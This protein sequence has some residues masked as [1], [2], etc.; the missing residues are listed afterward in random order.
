MSALEAIKQA[1][2][3]G[4]P[5]HSVVL[6]A[7]ASLAVIIAIAA[8]WTQAELSA[9]VTVASITLVALGSVFSYWRR[10][11]PLPLLK[12]VLAICVV[13]AFYWFFTTISRVATAGDLGSVEGP[14]AVLFTVIQVTHAFDVPSRRDLAFSLAGSATLM[15]VAAAQAIDITFGLYVVAWAVCGLI[16]LLSLWGSMAG[17]AN[18][19][20]RSVALVAV[21]VAVLGLA[22][23]VVL[24]APH[25]NSNLVLPSSLAGDVPISQPAA[26]VGG[27]AKGTQPLK[28]G[29]PSGQTRVG[30]YLGFA[31]PLDTAIRATLG[32]EIVFRVRADRPTFWLAE[33][34]DEWSGTSWSEAPTPK[35]TVAWRQVSSG[36]PFA[37]SAPVG[38]GFAGQPDYQ[39]FYIAQGGPNLVFHAANAS[40]VWFPASKLY[41]GP[42][43]TIRSGTSM[44]P[45]SIY[46]VLSDVDQA[47]P[48]QLAS[49][50]S[51]G[52]SPSERLPAAVMSQ[53]LQLPHP[54]RRAAALAH[55]VTAHATNT[56]AKV[57]ALEN[58]IG[59]HTKYTTDIPPLAP[60]QDTVNEFLFGNRRGYC[61]QI[62]TAL[63]VMLRSLGIPAREATG[64]VP[65]SYDPITD[66]YQEEAKDA[67]AWV[68]VWF[69]GYGWQSF[70]PTAFVPLANPSPGEV[71]GHDALQLLVK[72][73]WIPLAAVLCVLSLLVLAIR[74]VRAAPRTWAA[75]ISRQIERGARKA[76][77]PE[78]PGDTLVDVARRFDAHLGPERTAWTAESLADAAERAAFG[79]IELDR[80]TGRAL[81]QQA[82]RLRR[83]ARRS[84]GRPAPPGPRLQDTSSDRSQREPVG[85]PR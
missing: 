34:F 1:N 52:S 72:I 39:T 3:P 81:V 7:T 12:I 22:V 48:S 70:D 58:W 15:A 13:A 78:S 23:V 4:P 36:P 50:P 57:V 66:L 69:P 38:E 82:R 45:G 56:Y 19:R 49:A 59:A 37:M 33:T 84:S 17:G 64:Y 40:L 6:R 74:K 10:N 51:P 61:E 54:Y 11:R 85:T 32:N 55:R 73:P 16:G 75:A 20:L 14:L 80:A 2:Q 76:R 44:G 47:T 26:L 24:P 21:A 41:E 46:T 8:C 25:A 79:G 18:V 65:G 60:G 77:I 9:T 5:E 53:S 42:D 68:Q 27:G 28:A 67:H 30:G 29:S 62:S 83:R 43:G 71:I 63:A 35:G 31:G